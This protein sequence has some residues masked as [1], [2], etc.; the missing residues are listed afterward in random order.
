MMNIVQ[1]A[2]EYVTNHSTSNH[3]PYHGF[4]H[5]V[6]VAHAARMFGVS[7][8]LS[9]ELLDLLSVAWLFHDIDHLGRPDV[10]EGAQKIYNY[11][12]IDTQAHENNISNALQWFYTFA[13]LVSMKPECIE[14]VN[15]IIIWSR[16]PY[17]YRIG[18]TPAN[19]YLI[20]WFRDA[21]ILSSLIFHS[22]KAVLD[23]FCDEWSKSQE[24]M[25]QQQ[26]DFISGFKAKTGWGQVVYRSLAPNVLDQ[27][28]NIKRSLRTK[29]V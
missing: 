15:D 21:D 28:R 14:L 4:A 26:L 19:Q 12:G 6:S 22:P 17:E 2:T 3:L 24:E 5:A 8:S 13:G 18:F 25:V 10:F 20:N 16:Y 29:V 7:R 9:Q 27:L 23:M 11:S 1:K